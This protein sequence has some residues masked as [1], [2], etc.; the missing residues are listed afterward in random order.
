M[1][2]KEKAIWLVDK[3][4]GKEFMEIGNNVFGKSKI[5]FLTF[6]EAQKCALKCVDEILNELDGAGQKMRYNF[7][8]E[9]KQEIEL[10]K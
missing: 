9:V 6:T 8:L 4:Q 1:T 10:L 7:Y 3:F 2:Q 5:D